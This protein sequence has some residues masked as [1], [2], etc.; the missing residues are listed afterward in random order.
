MYFKLVNHSFIKQINIFFIEGKNNMIIHLKVI[1]NDFRLF[2]DDYVVEIMTGKKWFI[3]YFILK[4][5][6]NFY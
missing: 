5:K 1:N 3:I 6:M 4:I 2:Q